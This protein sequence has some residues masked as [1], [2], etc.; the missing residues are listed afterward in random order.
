MEYN[1]SWPTELDDDAAAGYFPWVTEHIKNYTMTKYPGMRATNSQGSDGTK[2]QYRP[3][4]ANDGMFDQQVLQSWD[5]YPV[6]KAI[7]RRW[8]TKGFFARTGGFKFA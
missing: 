3:L 6:L 7:Q 2:R 5:T 1:L 4:F 8:D